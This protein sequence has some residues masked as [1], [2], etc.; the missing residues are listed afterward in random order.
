MGSPLEHEINIKMWKYVCLATI[1][2]ADFL[3]PVM[4]QQMYKYNLSCYNT[5]VVKDLHMSTK[6][7]FKQDKKIF[8]LE[9]SCSG[10]LNSRQA[11]SVESAARSNPNFK[12]YVVFLGPASKEFILG[13]TYSTL[14]S[15]KNVYFVR[16]SLDKITKSKGTIRMK[17]VFNKIRNQ[18]G[19]PIHH[20]ADALRFLVLHEYGGVY[21]DL[22]MMVVK[23]LSALGKNWVSKESNLSPGSAA[24]RV[25]RDELGKNFSALAIK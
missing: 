9:T 1:V 2:F 17:K 15:M 20:M 6:Y 7:S 8:F 21:L 13:K 3:R 18:S 24:L 22:D 10:G 4:C 16:I 25:S 11:C 14:R 12:V 23:S 19:W 5:K